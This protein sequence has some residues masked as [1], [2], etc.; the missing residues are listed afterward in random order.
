[1]ERKIIDLRHKHIEQSI[2]HISCKLAQ[3]IDLL[4]QAKRSVAYSETVLI[5]AHQ[6][7]EELFIVLAEL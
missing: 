4:N 6:E 3:A 1:M 5:Q 2:T 7:L